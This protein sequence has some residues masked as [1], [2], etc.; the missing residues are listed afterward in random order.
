ML[1]T[2]AKISQHSHYKLKATK[3]SG[4]VGQFGVFTKLISS[5]QLDNPVMLSARGKLLATIF[6]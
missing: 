4:F 2:M 1:L 6:L 5:Y 3:A